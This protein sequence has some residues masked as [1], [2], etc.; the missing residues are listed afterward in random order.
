MYSY[1]HFSVII[2]VVSEFQTLI[3]MQ[4]ITLPSFFLCYNN[5][6]YLKSDDGNRK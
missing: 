2:T 1:L 5:H 6:P 4:E 3:F